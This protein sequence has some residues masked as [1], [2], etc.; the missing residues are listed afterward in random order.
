MRHM[1]HKLSFAQRSVFSLTLLV[2]ASSGWICHKAWHHQGT[3][4]PSKQAAK[5]DPIETAEVRRTA[6]T[7]ILSQM[8]GVSRAEIVKGDWIGRAGP[9]TQLVLL[10]TPDARAVD[11]LLAA[12]IRAFCCSYLEGLLPQD[13]TIV[14]GRTGRVI[15]KGPPVL[16]A[17]FAMELGNEE[18]QILVAIP[19]RDGMRRC[20]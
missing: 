20:S 15:T 12:R 18:K 3:A 14:D 6:L 7:Q 11:S 17:K 1:L 9:M 8:P 4:L 10:V 19:H 13:V 2:G 5:H 16:Q